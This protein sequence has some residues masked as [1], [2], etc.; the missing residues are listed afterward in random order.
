MRTGTAVTRKT[1]SQ[2]WGPVPTTAG[3][4][5]Q[6][7]GCQILALTHQVVVHL[8]S[9]SLTDPSRETEDKVALACQFLT[10]IVNERVADL[11]SVMIRGR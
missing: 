9:G 8:P 1:V 3:V 6:E 10:G 5:G 11:L 2:A 7:L 4:E